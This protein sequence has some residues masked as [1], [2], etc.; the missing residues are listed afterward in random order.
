MAIDG[1]RKA[2]AR[3]GDLLPALT[4]A[5]LLLY[6]LTWFAYRG[7]YSEFGLVAEDVGLTYSRVL[8]SAA[9]GLVM[10]L[11][12]SG[13]ILYAMA[14]ASDDTEASLANKLLPH[15]AP[16]VLIIAVRAVIFALAM[17]CGLAL[18]TAA[19]RAT[20]VIFDHLPS[21]GQGA[22]NGLARFVVGTGLYIFFL[23]AAVLLV[24]HGVIPGARWA[25]RE[26]SKATAPLT[27]TGCVIL[28]AVIVLGPYYAGRR[29][30]HD[31]KEG[32]VSGGPVHAVATR[33]LLDIRAD[34]VDISWLAPKGTCGDFATSGVIYLGGA[35]GTT[36]LYDPT[37][38]TVC[39]TPTSSVQILSRP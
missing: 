2:L 25:L 10:L 27:L 33:W 23:V 13:L 1:V 29:I 14:L 38:R 31:I 37:K 30:G 19:T 7:V 18:L 6:A 34:R 12:G 9:L 5:G 22:L 39:R 21:I 32:Q 17:V 28:V 15:S 20:A 26:A 36:I 8:A 4:L 35:D 11:T 24:I 3:S 16:K